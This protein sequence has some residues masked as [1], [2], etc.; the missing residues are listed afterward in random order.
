MLS[1]LKWFCRC[2]FLLALS[3][4]VTYAADVQSQNLQ[5]L[6]GFFRSSF[7]N[8]TLPSD[9]HIG[10]LGINYFADITPTFYG[11]IGTY[12]AITGTQGG[13]FVLAMGGGWQIQIIHLVSQ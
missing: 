2:I 5:H 8:V 13:L 9:Q 11:G 7:D 4:S 12:G 10:L 1:P 6:S 3:T